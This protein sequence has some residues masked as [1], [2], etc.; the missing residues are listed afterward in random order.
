MSDEEVENFNNLNE[1]DLTF[2]FLRMRGNAFLYKF[3]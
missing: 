2:I 1:K 3:I